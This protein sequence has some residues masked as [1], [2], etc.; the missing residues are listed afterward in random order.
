MRPPEGDEAHDRMSETAGNLS[1][2]VAYKA[3]EVKDRSES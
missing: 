2:K 3:D 1:D